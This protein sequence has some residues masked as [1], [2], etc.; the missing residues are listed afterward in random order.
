MGFIVVGVDG[1]PASEAALRRAAGEAGRRG[2]IVS[3]VMAWDDPHRD[4][5]L[6]SDPPGVDALHPLRFKL[7][8]I[9]EGVLGDRPE[10]KVDATVL[11]GHPAQV[12][13][14]VAHDADLLVVGNRGRSGFVSAV[15]GSVSAAC[16]AHAT[17]PV[18]I[19]H[20]PS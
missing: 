2:D 17:C 19:V 15:L 8:R 7:D 3:V 4:M 13:V 12:L 14:D 11:E 9:V 16:A 20:A 6:P 1:S 5:W 18:V 10:V